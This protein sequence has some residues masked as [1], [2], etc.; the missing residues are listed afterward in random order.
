MCS[1]IYLDISP[2][3]QFP[4]ALTTA[5]HG[6]KLDESKLVPSSDRGDPTYE[7]SL[8]DIALM[9]KFKQF[10]LWNLKK[11]NKKKGYKVLTNAD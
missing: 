4:K 5:T 11:I 3:I 10:Y 1:P 8:S 9:K 7:S 2:Y 6:S